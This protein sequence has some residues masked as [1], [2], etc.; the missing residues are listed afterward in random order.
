MVTMS[1]IKDTKVGEDV[2]KWG[3]SYIAAGNEN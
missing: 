3:H 2:K 1:K